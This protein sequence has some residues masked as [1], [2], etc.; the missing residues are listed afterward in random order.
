MLDR[1]VHIAE[2]TGEQ[3]HLPLEI[4]GNGAGDLGRVGEG[5]PEVHVQV[6][7]PLDVPA[8]ATSQRMGVVAGLIDGLGLQRRALLTAPQTVTD[9]Q[10]MALHLDEQH[11][12]I[13]MHE[14]DVGLPIDGVIAHAHIGDHQPGVVETVDERTHDLTLGVVLQLL[15]PEA[16]RDQEPHAAP[17]AGVSSGQSMARGP[18]TRAVHEIGGALRSP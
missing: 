1:L 7:E 11:S 4:H 18:P 3:D 8:N 13:G 6:L 15:H 9:P 5:E 16:F 17:L 12:P 10:A 2:V 14:H